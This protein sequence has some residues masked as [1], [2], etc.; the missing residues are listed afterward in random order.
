MK[1]EPFKSAKAWYNLRKVREMEKSEE[2]ARFVEISK[3]DVVKFTVWNE[4]NRASSLNVHIGQSGSR[5][6]TLTGAGWLDDETVFI[7]HRCGLRLGIFRMGTDDGPLWSAEIDFQT[8]IA[9]VTKLD[10]NTWEAAVSGCWECL[11]ERYELKRILQ[12]SDEYSLRVLERKNH[13][14]RDFCHGVGYD[15]HQNLGYSLSIG[16]DPRFIVEKRVFRLPY[17]WGVRDLYYDEARRAYFVIAVSK[18][19]KLKSY[20]NVKASL[21]RMAENQDSWACLGVYDNVQGD[22]LAVW[23]GLVWFSDQI[24]N[25]LLAANAATGDLELICTGNA[26]DFP[27]G[28][29]ISSKGLL[30]VTN[31]GNSS[32]IVLDACELE[33]KCKA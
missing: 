29:A 25:R 32:W 13:E 10:E 5:E 6:S 22:G 31:Y 26:F 21:W 9:A 16:K 27:H 18:A 17:P 23:G 14:K 28:V 20:G 15:K 1:I 7:A 8:D 4:P 24:G 30:A 12:G 33:A 11:Y 2:T 3:E 19:P